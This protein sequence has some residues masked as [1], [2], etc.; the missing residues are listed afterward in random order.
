[1]AAIFGK[2]KKHVMAVAA[3]DPHEIMGGNTR[4]EMVDVDWRMRMAK[5]RELMTDGVTIFYPQTCVI[6]R[7]VSI[8]ADTVIEPFVQILGKTRIGSDCRIRSYTVINNSVIGDG[9]LQSS[10]GERDRRG[11]ACRKFR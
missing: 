8:G 1:M 9:V 2:A 10:P 6:D 7:D 5:C 11:R 3:N 4:A